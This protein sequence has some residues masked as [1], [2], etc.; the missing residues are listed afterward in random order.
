MEARHLNPVTAQVPQMIVEVRWETF[1]CLQN[2]NACRTAD[3]SLPLSTGRD[4]SDAV[5][6]IAA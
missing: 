2:A 6:A 3:S 1:A 5:M 4:M